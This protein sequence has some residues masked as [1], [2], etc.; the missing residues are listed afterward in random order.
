MSRKAFEAQIKKQFPTASDGLLLGRSSNGRY[1]SMITE[2]AWLAWQAATKAALERA[3]EEVSRVDN[4]TWF[5]N[6]S[7]F[8]IACRAAIRALKYETE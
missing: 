4:E 5:Q 2:H 6:Q 8:G 1:G 3:A 7:A